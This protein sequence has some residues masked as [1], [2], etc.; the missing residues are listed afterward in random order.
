MKRSTALTTEHEYGT[1]RHHRHSSLSHRRIH[2][3]NTHGH[4]HGMTNFLVGLF[5]GWVAFTSTGREAIAI[6]YYYADKASDKIVERVAEDM[7]KPV[8]PRSK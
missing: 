4:G 2:I 7:P 6:A 8:P 1:Y 3:S 5:V